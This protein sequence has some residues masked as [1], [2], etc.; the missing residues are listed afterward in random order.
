[1]QTH[2]PG[3]VLDFRQIILDRLKE[4]GKTVHG[5]SQSQRAAHAKTVQIF[6]Y[7][8]RQ[9]RPD[10]LGLLMGE[11]DLTVTRRETLERLAELEAQEES[12]KLLMESLNEASQNMS[13]WRK[14]EEYARCLVKASTAKMVERY[15]ARIRGVL[16]RMDTRGN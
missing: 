1:M 3:E 9:I 2:T 11:L 16:N 15:T 6:L 14:L 8:G 12:K 4:Q 13:D 10:T 5:F 7:Q